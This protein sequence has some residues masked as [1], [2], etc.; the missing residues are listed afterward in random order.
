MTFTVETGKIV[1]GANSYV[2]LTYADEYNALFNPNAGWDS[3]EDA[4]KETALIQATRSVDIL[5]GLK[6]ASQILSNT[7]NL[8]W[9]R[10][11]FYDRNNRL[12]N[13]GVIPDSLK[14]A[15]CEIALKA[16]AE[17]DLIPNESQK[18][19][20]GNEAIAVG[21]ISV[22]TTYKKSQTNPQ[23]ENFG[24]VESILA[25]IFADRKVLRIFR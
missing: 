3:Y 8:L 14:D 24:K 16:V 18:D 22:N 19:M 1:A 4:Q 9:P 12:I 21:P 6:Y 11:V 10:Y 5:Y 23:Y 25:D 2:D 13:A 17:E 7:Q 15:V 20:I